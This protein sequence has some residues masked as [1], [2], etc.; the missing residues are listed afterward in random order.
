MFI[1]E[2]FNFQNLCFPHGEMLLSTWQRYLQHLIQCNSFIQLG[3]EALWGWNLLRQNTTQC[4]R[5]NFELESLHWASVSFVVLSYRNDWSQDC[6]LITFSVYVAAVRS[7]IIGIRS[8]LSSWHSIVSQWAACPR[9]GRWVLREGGM[10]LP[11]FPLSTF[12]FM[13]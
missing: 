6:S 3:L 1:T 9:H 13:S 4:P 8:L 10:T 12:A 11:N 7:T 5:P 2:M